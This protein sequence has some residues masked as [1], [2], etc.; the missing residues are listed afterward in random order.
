MVICPSGWDLKPTL[1]DQ[2][3]YQEVAVCLSLLLPFDIRA[4]SIHA[5]AEM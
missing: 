4:I 5:L 1:Q 2:L 3:T